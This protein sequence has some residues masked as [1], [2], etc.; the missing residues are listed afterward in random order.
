MVKLTFYVSIEKKNI[1]FKKNEHL[2]NM[3]I[4]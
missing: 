2:S 1:V 3:K 4:N